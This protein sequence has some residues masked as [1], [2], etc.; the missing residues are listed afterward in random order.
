[1]SRNE[2]TLDTSP[3]HWKQFALLVTFV[4]LGTTLLGTFSDAIQSFGALVV[5]VAM[6][7][8]AS[9]TL[10]TL[11]VLNIFH[12]RQ[13]REEKWGKEKAVL[14]REKEEQQRYYANLIHEVIK[15]E[16]QSMLEDVSPDG[17]F[18]ERLTE[19]IKTCELSQSFIDMQNNDLFDLMHA[20]EFLFSN[21]LHSEMREQYFYCEIDP[22]LK[23][24]Y[25]D[26]RQKYELT[27]FLRECLNNIRKYANYKHVGL[28][29]YLEKKG[30]SQPNV[31]EIVLE[32][33][34]D[35]RGLQKG[36][37]VV[38]QELEINANNVGLFRELYLR[39]RR[40]TGIDEMFRK[41]MRMKGELLIR[42]IVG[43]GTQV[44]LRF[45]PNS[46]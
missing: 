14:I 16:A 17:P 4:I 37:G 6:A 32:I 8:I 42:S 28:I 21:R 41:A 31:S 44:K 34:D 30:S 12:E 24:V 7:I 9:L 20:M 39:G 27:F 43:E 19:F 2:S 29:I 5:F 25:L 13:Y 46:G 3:I 38:D 1:M 40:C 45:F 10:L 22:A 35:G 23:G 36:L 18:Y 33:K 15:G 26:Y 11:Y